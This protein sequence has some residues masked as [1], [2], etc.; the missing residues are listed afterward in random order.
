M[1]DVKKLLELGADIDAKDNRQETPLHLAARNGHFEVVKML[2]E[3]GANITGENFLKIKIS[4]LMSTTFEFSCQNVFIK[5]L[6]NGIFQSIQNI[7]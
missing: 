2:L 6:E 3:N 5:L 4:L 7:K 1:K